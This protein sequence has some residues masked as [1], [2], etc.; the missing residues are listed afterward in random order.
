MAP[1]EVAALEGWARVGIDVGGTFTDFVLF[2]P[3]TGALTYHKQPST[4]DDPSRAVAEGLG[5]LLTRASLRPADIGVLM[6]GTTIG[7]NAVIQ[8]KG[9]KVALLV[10]RGFRDV[11]EIG[12]S[13]MPSSLNFHAVKEVPLVPRSQVVEIAARLDARGAPLS[14]PDEAELDRAAADLRHLAPDAVALMIVNGYVDPVFEAEIAGAIAARLPGVPVSSAAVI[15]PEIRE[16]ERTLVAC[17]NAAIQPLMQGY[18]DRLKARLA[19]QGTHAPVFVTSSAG[20]SLG[21]ESARARP[22]E[23]LLSGPASGVMAATRL[24]AQAGVPRIIT[25]DMGGTSSDIAIAHD[26]RPEFA[27]R[28]EIGGLPLVLP[29]VAVSAIG[30]G[31]GSVVSIDAHGVLK[32]GPESAGADPG[33]IAYGRGGTRPT[34][35]DCY[36][37]TGIIDPDRFLGGRLRLDV[38]AARRALEAIAQGIRLSGDHLAERAALGA[39]RVATAG[40][41]TEM[42]KTMASR[43]LDPATF[44]LMP[45]GGAGPT[46]ASFLADDA[47]IDEIVV[48]AAAATFCALGAAA[49]DLRRDFARSLR[50]RVNAA[51]TSLMRDRLALMEQEARDWLAGEGRLARRV[52]FAAAADMRYV[53]QAYE[54]KVSLDGLA[55]NPD[56]VREAFHRVHEGLYG[57]RDE[58]AEVDCGTVRLAIIGEAEPIAMPAMPPGGNVPIPRAMRRAFFSDRFVEAAV[59]DRGDLTAGTLIQGPAIVEQSDTTTPVLPGWQLRLDAVGNLRLTREAP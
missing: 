35:T 29:V 57:F 39:L 46:H 43:G 47:G 21:L 14:R 33:P 59:Y 58:A 34:I 53:G 15:W 25:F 40:M 27:T 16:Y 13:R 26:G 7:L 2:D 37:V 41:V 28:T 42:I 45:F 9:A 10:S 1:S 55:L 18:F 49:A 50:R 36:L 32:V 48:P 19:A 31:G 4:P 8:R 12:R 3:R 23:T 51:G 38:E 22:V 20:G 30:A 56:A 11:L 54:L 24:A 52:T 44:A 6:H 5:E 17:M